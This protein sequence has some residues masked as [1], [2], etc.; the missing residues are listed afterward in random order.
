VATSFERELS[1]Y[2]QELGFNKYHITLIERGSIKTTFKALGSTFM[3]IFDWSR[4]DWPCDRGSLEVEFKWFDFFDRTNNN[5]L[6]NRSSLELE[7]W[8]I[9]HFDWTTC[10]HAYDRASQ[11]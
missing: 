10:N 2:E 6:W 8:L 5:N 3:N 4:F 9:H 11:V 7:I 1:S